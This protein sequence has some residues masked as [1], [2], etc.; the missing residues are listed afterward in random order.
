[1]NIGPPDMRIP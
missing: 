1:M